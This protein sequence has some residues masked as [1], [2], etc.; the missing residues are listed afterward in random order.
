M[1]FWQLRE[2]VQG[3]TLQ[4]LS[5]YLC[6]FF[7]CVFIF[8]HLIFNWKKVISSIKWLSVV[9]FISMCLAFATFKYEFFPYDEYLFFLLTCL[10]FVLQ[11][12]IHSFKIGQYTY[13]SDDCMRGWLVCGKTGSGKT[14]SGLMYIMHQF[15]QNFQNIGGMCLDQKG[16]FHT[17]VRKVM[18]HYG[19]EDRLVTLEVRPENSPEN[20]E[21]A[22]TYNIISYPG[23]PA[24]SYA[25]IIVDTAQAQ[26]GG[27]S[28]NMFFVTAARN[29]IGTGIEFL[30]SIDGSATLA[31]T[32]ELLTNEELLEERIIEADNITNKSLEFMATLTDLKSFMNSPDDQRGGVIGTVS[33]YLKPFVHPEIA[34]VFSPEQNSVELEEMDNGF[35]FCISLPQKYVKERN[36]IN[37]IM[38]LLYY[39]HVLKRF[40]TPEELKHKNVL[41]L[42]AD[43]AQGLITKSEGGMADFN[44]LDKIREA[45]GTAIFATQ[46]TKSFIPVLGRDKT[47]VLLLNLA[48][49]LI[50]QSAHPDDAKLS[51]DLIGKHQIVKRSHGFSGGKRS[52]NYQTVDEYQI[53]PEVLTKFKKFEC[54]VMHCDKGYYRTKLAPLGSNGH[55]AHW[56]GWRKYYFT[57]LSLITWPLKLILS[58]STLISQN[59]TQNYRKKS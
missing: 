14:A 55:I 22:E 5:L 28:G 30:Q 34:E 37:T 42:W 44:V 53:K 27:G 6:L 46:S 20:W 47:D 26:E 8:F 38:K 18:R 13:S 54:I 12:Q 15:F 36:Y 52:A 23:I 31:G 25:A 41:T 10:S 16:N 50:F 19:F 35:I 57:I 11:R 51:A 2:Y 7:L 40:D 39:T 33:N 17:I 56:Y 1:N 32:Y 21:P 3:L 45:K 43:E 29:I 58:A 48:N 24:S 49:K 9:S 59:K 4:Q